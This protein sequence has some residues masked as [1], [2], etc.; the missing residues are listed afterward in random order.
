MWGIVEKINDANSHQHS[1]ATQQDNIPRD[2]EDNLANF[3]GTKIVDLSKDHRV[4]QKHSWDE[5]V[6]Q[7]TDLLKE[8]QTLFTINGTER[9]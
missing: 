3:S 8:Y 2:T 1:V 7:I 4:I 9:K 6:V 5:A